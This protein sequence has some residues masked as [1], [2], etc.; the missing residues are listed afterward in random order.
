MMPLMAA[1]TRLIRVDDETLERIEREQRPRESKGETLRRLLNIERE[2]RNEGR[3][4][5]R[6]AS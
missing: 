2:T 1:A 4:E 6:R 3:P 5:R